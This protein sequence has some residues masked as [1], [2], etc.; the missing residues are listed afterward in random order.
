MTSQ[1]FSAPTVAWNFPLSAPFRASSWGANTSTSSHREAFSHM[2]VRD[3]KTLFL[4]S[5]K[6]HAQVGVGMIRTSKG[7]YWCNFFSSSHKNSSFVLE[8]LEHGGS[9]FNIVAFVTLLKGEIG[10]LYPNAI[11]VSLVDRK[12]YTSI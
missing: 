6:T 11:N 7:S 5:N 4:L 2:L 8:A 3:K 1:R 12:L 9:R 10:L